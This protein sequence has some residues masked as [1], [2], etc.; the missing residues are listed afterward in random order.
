MWKARLLVVGGRLVIP[1]AKVNQ[2]MIYH[3]DKADCSRVC[4]SLLALLDKF[5]HLLKLHMI[6]IVCWCMRLLSCSQPDAGS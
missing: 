4:T 3:L 1:M 5:H 2:K 6:T